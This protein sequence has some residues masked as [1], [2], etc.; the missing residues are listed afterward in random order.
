[1]RENDDMTQAVKSVNV[2]PYTIQEDWNHS[3][4]NIHNKEQFMGLASK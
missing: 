1:V 4:I 2:K 3:A